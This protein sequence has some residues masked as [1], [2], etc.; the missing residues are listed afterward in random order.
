MG[1]FS[2][3]M[4][5]KEKRLNIFKARDGIGLNQPYTESRNG[6]STSTWFYKIVLKL[7]LTIKVI[8]YSSLF[9]STKLLC[10]FAPFC[11]YC[12][13]MPYWCM[14]QRCIWCVRTDFWVFWRTKKSAGNA[15]FLLFLGGS[16]PAQWYD[17]GQGQNAAWCIVC[18]NCR[19]IS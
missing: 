6:I 4:E 5:L 17:D 15:S 1:T 12:L 9:L 2:L 13:F 16:Q 7:E 3:R 19:A 8:L 11:F 18:R 10:P 14:H